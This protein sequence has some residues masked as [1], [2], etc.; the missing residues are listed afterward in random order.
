MMSANE[1]PKIVCNADA[2]D[3]A[4]YII[5][6]EDH[7]LGN[8]LRYMLIRKCVRRHCCPSAAPPRR[9]SLSLLYLLALSLSAAP[10]RLRPFASDKSSSLLRSPKVN[11]CGYSIPHP[12]E[13]KMNMR[14]QTTPGE[15]ALGAAQCL[16]RCPQ[17]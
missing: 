2:A 13:P 9:L 3:K 6:G 16:T 12:S 15:P 4:T 17:S 5:T 8:A 14:L 1:G 11:F 10:L 7:T